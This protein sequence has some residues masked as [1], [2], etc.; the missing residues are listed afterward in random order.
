M[1]HYQKYPWRDS[2]SDPVRLFIRRNRKKILII[3]GIGIVLVI[4][5]L[6]A[7]AIFFFAVVLPTGTNI[8]QQAVQSGGAASTAA[9]FIQ[10][11]QQTLGSA[12][13]MQWAALFLQFNN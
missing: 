9:S 3:L 8:A 13:L 1:S 2:P 12:N 4:A 7:L 5:A 6:I 10:W 11:V